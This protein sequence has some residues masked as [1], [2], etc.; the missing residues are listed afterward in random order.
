MKKKIFRS[1][2]TLSF[3]VVLCSFTAD[4]P[5]TLGILRVVKMMAYV[6]ADLSEKSYMAS[7]FLYALPPFSQITPYKTIRDGD[8]KLNSVSL[9][10]DPLIKIYHDS[11]TRTNV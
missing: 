7:S 2:F 1:L 10:F 4:G 8:I 5:R 11:I 3:V 9:F 6:D